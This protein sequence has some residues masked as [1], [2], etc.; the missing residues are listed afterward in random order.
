MSRPVVVGVSTLL[1]GRK[2]GPRG[3]PFSF[4]VFSF[5]TLSK[6]LKF[7]GPP[8]GSK[9]QCFPTADERSG[10]TNIMTIG[11]CPTSPRITLSL[12][13]MSLSLR[14]RLS[15]PVDR[16]TGC[17]GFLLCPVLRCATHAPCPPAPA[18]AAECPFCRARKM[19][20]GAQGM[21]CGHQKPVGFRSRHYRTH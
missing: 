9:N 19:G 3:S 10:P 2:G 6:S 8:T 7:Q 18:A 17:H 21:H 1:L 14:L 11:L 12:T 16:M 20:N 13:Q 15:D 4:F 5:C